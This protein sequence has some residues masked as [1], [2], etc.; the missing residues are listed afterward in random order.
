[1]SRD[2]CIFSLALFPAAWRPLCSGAM[3]AHGAHPLPAT[4]LVFLSRLPL[5]WSLVVLLF[6]AFSFE[7]SDR[8]KKTNPQAVFFLCRTNLSFNNNVLFRA[9]LIK[10]TST[11]R[12]VLLQVSFVTTTWCSFLTVTFRTLVPLV[13]CSSV[14]ILCHSYSVGLFTP[15]FILSFLFHFFLFTIRKTS[16]FSLAVVE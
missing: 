15:S 10:K 2:C 9:V 12:R 7:L 16:C 6:S 5:G 14:S 8:W 4:L 1:M 11:T 3:K 13:T